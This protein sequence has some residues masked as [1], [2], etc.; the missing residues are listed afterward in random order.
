MNFFQRQPSGVV[1]PE[2]Y[3]TMGKLMEKLKVQSLP[4]G[5]HSMSMMVDG[6][7]GEPR[8]SRKRSMPSS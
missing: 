8:L 6:Q 3:I 5:M 1:E 7:N 2:E 4:A